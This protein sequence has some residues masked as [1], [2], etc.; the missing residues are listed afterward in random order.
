M[1]SKL[2]L[3]VWYSDVNTV[4]NDVYKIKNVETL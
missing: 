1:H 4:Y 2:M 3:C